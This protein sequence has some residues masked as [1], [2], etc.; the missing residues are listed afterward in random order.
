VN[1][2]LGLVAT[3]A[4]A[5]RRVVS[6]GLTLS[7]SPVTGLYRRFADVAHETDRRIG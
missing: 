1:E 5:L 6:H 7:R 4:A 3:A 2:V